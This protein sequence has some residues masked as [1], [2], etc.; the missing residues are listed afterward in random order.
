[1]TQIFNSQTFSPQ[2]ASMLNNVPGQSLGATNTP[3]QI[4]LAQGNLQGTMTQPKQAG[5]SQPQSSTQPLPQ[6]TM[7]LG[8]FGRAMDEMRSKLGQNQELVNQKNKLLTLVYDRQ[9]T[10]EEK[11]TLTPSQQ[12]AIESGNIGLIQGQVR[13]INDTLKGRTQSIDKSISYLTSLYQQD[14]ENAENQKQQA[15]NTILDY[16]KT[17]G[18]KPSVVAEALG[19]DKSLGLKLDAL[20]PPPVSGDDTQVVQLSDGRDVLIDK[21]TG[22]TIKIIGGASGGGSI[23]PIA[24]SVIDGVI[25]LEDL[26]PTVRGQIAPE[27][28]A[29]GYKSGPKLSSGQQDDLAQM[30]TVSGQITELLNY[31]S[32]GKLEGIGFGSG[33]LG[34]LT[35]KIFGTGSEEAKNVRSLI[36]QI[37]G[38]IAKLRG[39]TSFTSNE[40]KLLNTYT[41]SIN[42]SAASA[43]SKL[44]GLQKFIADKKAHTLDFAQ[45]RGVPDTSG[46]STYKGFNL[47]Y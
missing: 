46:G 5:T 3:Q 12:Q 21:K 40:E 17:L 30:D 42:E 11:S 1:M 34:T 36:G 37:K 26:T 20:M 14:I 16:S 8:L 25:R 47:P 24:Q 38:T 10:P 39:G 6:P 19:Y 9:L 33:P 18:Q 44:V 23:S 13:I 22:N 7:N 32:D 28:T 43:I 2:Q 27:L 4:A 45:E 41:P 15:L 35:T 31:N 29:A